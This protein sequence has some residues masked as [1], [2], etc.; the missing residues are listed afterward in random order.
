MYFCTRGVDLCYKENV[1]LYIVEYI[2]NSNMLA[3]NLCT[4]ITDIQ[5]LKLKRN[6]LKY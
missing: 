2:T 4:S 3:K 5:A 6:N 1:I